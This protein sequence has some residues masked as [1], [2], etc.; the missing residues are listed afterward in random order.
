M[1]LLLVEDERDLSRALSLILHKN[2]YT[3]DCAYDGEEAEL[4]LK[5]NA[6]DAI[7]LDIMLPK[8]NGIEILKDM[9]KK[10]NQTPVIILSA[11]SEIKDRIIGLDI[12]ADDY[13]PKPFDVAELL[14]RIRALTRRRSEKI[15]T[16]LSFGNVS[17]NRDNSIMSTEFGEEKLLNKEL[18]IMELFFLNHDRIISWEEIVN[19]AWPL[20]SYSINNNLW[21]FLSYIRKKL[22][23]IKANIVIKN[24]RN[25]GYRVEIE[26]AKD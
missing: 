10:D 11:K 23:N 8:K 2:N 19:N 6:Y 15:V 4:F 12:G 25:L 24:Y 26:D 16:N 3:V 9:R 5:G 18:Q 1:K 17:L 20:D 21:V 14:A 13:L 22:T 7:I